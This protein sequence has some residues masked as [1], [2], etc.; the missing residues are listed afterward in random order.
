M[1]RV[2]AESA[3]AALQEAPLEGDT[4]EALGTLATQTVNRNL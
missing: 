4:Y 3:L 2:R 1:I